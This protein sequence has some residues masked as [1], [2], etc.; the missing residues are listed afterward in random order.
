[1]R[2]I[3]VPTDFSDCASNALEYAIFLSKK[4]DA[5]IVLLSAY[6]IPSSGAATIIVNIQEDLRKETQEEL[7]SLIALKTKK[8]SG[9]KIS[10]AID[11]NIPSNSIVRMVNKIEF[12]MVVL[13]TTGASGFKDIFLGST[14]SAIINK[15]K[16]PILA[17]PLNSSFRK[18]D[19]LLM[20]C[21]LDSVKSVDS[22]N[23]FKLFATKLNF[24]VKFLNIVQEN[25][26][27]VSEKLF[28]KNERLKIVFNSFDYDIDL[29]KSE[30]VEKAILDAVEEKH[31]L[32]VVTRER[33]F[34]DKLFHSSMSKK[35][36]KHSTSPILILHE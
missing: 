28:K 33:T 16:I 2:K 20:A 5:E 3:L 18:I 26:K 4:L 35:L 36:A 7:D 22:I 30:D 13:G 9:L 6:H 23:F 34:F 21:N 8:Y 32:S 11:F 17:V 15:V 31:L 14:T 19:T 12:D 29:I 10:S 24:K 27:N 1:M 25:D